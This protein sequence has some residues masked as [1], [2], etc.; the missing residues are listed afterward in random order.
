MPA[1]VSSKSERKAIFVIIPAY[2]E[3]SQ[4]A[5]VLESV[6]EE[7]YTVVVVDDG[8]SDDTTDVAR[9]FPVHLLRHPINL[10]QGAALETGMTYAR[11]KGASVAVHFDAD[12]QHDARQIKELTAPIEK[13]ETDVVLGSRFLRKSDMLLVPRGRRV[14][15]QVGRIVSGMLTN[16]WL[17]DT[18]NGFR[19]LSRTALEKIRLQEKG[20]GHATEILDQIRRHQLRHVEMPATVQYSEYSMQK[21]QATANGFSILVDLLVWKLFR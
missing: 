1:R 21:G 15:L 7:G 11:R 2:N 12:G 9:S 4:L 18:H 3:S 16:V 5:P 14:A 17:R 10:G 6:V 13:G 8:S 19:A 20:F